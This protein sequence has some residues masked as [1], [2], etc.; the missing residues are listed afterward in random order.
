VNI[1]E[2]ADVALTPTAAAVFRTLAGTTGGLAGREVAR[3]SGVSPS[4]VVDILRAAEERGLVTSEHHGNVKINRLNRQHLAADAVIALVSMRRRMIDLLAEEVSSWAAVPVHA[5][6]YGSAAR[7]D[8][9]VRSDLDVLLVRADDA[10]DDLWEA[11]LYRSGQRLQAATGNAVSWLTMTP[12]DLARVQRENEAI[13]E[14]WGR[15]A[16]HLA[17]GKLPTTLRNAVKAR[18]V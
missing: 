10:D 3:L 16:V 4:R 2:P 1:S 8:G 7:G 9:S 15:D 17:G 12:A 6:L 18:P 14:E 11:Q 5:S 13:V